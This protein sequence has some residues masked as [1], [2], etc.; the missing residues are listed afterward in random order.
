MTGDKRGWPS[1]RQ[2]LA[3]IPATLGLTGCTGLRSGD[4][5]GTLLDDPPALVN[6]A[7]SYVGI[8]N[9]AV[10]FVVEQD[11]ET[12]HEQTYEFEGVD[13]SEV[14]EGAGVI[15]GAVGESVRFEGEPWMAERTPYAVHADHRGGGA[16]TYTTDDY[17]EAYGDRDCPEFVLVVTVLEERVDLRGGPAPPNCRNPIPFP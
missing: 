14:E 6:L 7:L 10:E 2:Y 17:I 8:S 16:G 13:P 12:V 15:G 3:G 11:G 1:R 9:T 5:D 4:D